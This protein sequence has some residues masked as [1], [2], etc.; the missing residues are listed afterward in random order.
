VEQLQSENTFDV[1]IDFELPDTDALSLAGAIRQLPD[2]PAL[3]SLLVTSARPRVGDPGAVQTRISASIYK[4]SRPRRLFE[5]RSQTF[6]SKT[7][8]P[9]NSTGII[10]VRPVVCGSSSAAILMADDN[11]INQKVGR[12]FL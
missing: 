6:D 8:F 2:D 11:R 1:A 5:A 7:C 10:D 3:H 4:P 12:G 9:S